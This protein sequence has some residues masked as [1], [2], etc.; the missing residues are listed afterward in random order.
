MNVFLLSWLDGF[1]IRFVSKWSYA[2]AYISHIQLQILP[3]DELHKYVI[4][5]GLYKFIM[6]LNFVK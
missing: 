2:L 5:P 1:N 4:D 6:L 3:G